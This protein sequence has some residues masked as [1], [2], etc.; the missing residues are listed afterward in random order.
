MFAGAVASSIY[1]NSDNVLLGI[2]STEYHLGL[3][4]ASTKI[5]LG[6][7]FAFGYVFLAKY[8]SLKWNLPDYAEIGVCI[9]G[10]VLGYSG[11]MI[12]VNSSLW[13]EIKMHL[14]D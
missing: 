7:I 14:D 11:I 5:Y 3:Y 6:C 13:Q 12:H 4:A 2:L 9:L 8:L 10:S 1:V